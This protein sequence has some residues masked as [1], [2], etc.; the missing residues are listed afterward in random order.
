M[1][2]LLVLQSLV[3]RA[4]TVEETALR[5]LDRGIEAY[6][7]G[8]YPRARRELDE[9]RR[10]VPHKPNPYRWLGMTARQLGDCAGAVRHFDAFLARV[11]PGDPRV[12]EVMQMRAE[13]ASSAAAAPPITVERAPP[14]ASPVTR[15][16]W[17]WAAVGGAAAITGV[18]LGLVLASGDDPGELPPIVCGPTGC[19]A[20]G[21]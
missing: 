14:T 21:S 3:A 6:R 20:G 16:W 18:T 19:R 12:P 13:C 1:C 9:A 15:R 10:L 2:A 7:V 8:D 11:A 4:E 17:F 5:H